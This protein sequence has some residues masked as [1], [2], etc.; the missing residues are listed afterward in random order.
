MKYVRGYVN[1]RRIPDKRALF[2][3]ISGCKQGCEKCKNISRCG[4]EGQELTE[5]VMT[6]TLKTFGKTIDCV[7]FVGG[8]NY[9]IELKNLC[10]QVHKSGLETS[11]STVLDPSSIGK[12][13]TDELDYL[14]TGRC[15]SEQ[16][17]LKRDYCP[18]ADTYD[19]VEA[20]TR[21]LTHEN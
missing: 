7:C 8:E 11:L 21:T 19:W 2:I 4:E 9:S 6:E 17:A 1:S 18:F 3:E 20:K 14:L 16:S 13:L 5:S 15:D 12:Q 10:K